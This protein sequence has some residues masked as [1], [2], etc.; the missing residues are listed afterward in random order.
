MCSNIVDVNK[1]AKISC[2]PLVDNQP[3]VKDIFTVENKK[4]LLR[5]QESNHHLLGD[6]Q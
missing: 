1:I 5:Q 6:N 3:T 4:A 2:K